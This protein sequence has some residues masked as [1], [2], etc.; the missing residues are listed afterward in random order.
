MGIFE[1]ARKE[2]AEKDERE[3]R[4]AQQEQAEGGQRV[5]HLLAQFEGDCHDIYQA[6]EDK[7]DGKGGR[8]LTH[9]Q[10]GEKFHIKSPSRGLFYFNGGNALDEKQMAKV[11]LQEMKGLIQS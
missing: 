7:E 1:D 9:K 6:Y 2:L 11:M 8:I 3:R 4:K 5:R 10:T